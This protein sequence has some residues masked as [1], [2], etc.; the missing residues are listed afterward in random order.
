LVGTSFKIVPL[1]FVQKLFG[2]NEASK[3]DIRSSWFGFVL[4]RIYNL[5]FFRTL[6]SKNNF[7]VL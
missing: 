1:K 4:V 6:K 3:E 5:N 2:Q 7:S